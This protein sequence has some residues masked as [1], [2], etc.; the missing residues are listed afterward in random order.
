M[1]T[2]EFS[3]NFCPLTLGMFGLSVPD[4]TSLAFTGFLLFK[5]EGWV[6]MVTRVR[7]HL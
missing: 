1:A 3:P 6:K 2:W 4:E 5:R 7:S